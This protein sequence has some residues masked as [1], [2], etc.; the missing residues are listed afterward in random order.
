MKRIAA[1]S[2]L[3]AVLCAC[4]ASPP[5]TAAAPT[6]QTAI[7]SPPEPNELIVGEPRAEQEYRGPT[8]QEL[9]DASIEHIYSVFAKQYLEYAICTSAAS[10][11]NECKTMLAHFCERDL[12]LDTRGG[13]HK[14]P[15]CATKCEKLVSCNTQNWQC[16]CS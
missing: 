3:G 5:P 7:V 12:H 13:W 4:A 6:S 15:Y 14:K 2:I 10:N 11:M 16:S 8:E 9:Y 1:F